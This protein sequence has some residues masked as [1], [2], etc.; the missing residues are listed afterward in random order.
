MPTCNHKKSDGLRQLAV[1]GR[2]EQTQKYNT[3]VFLAEL[4]IIFSSF[5]FHRPGRGGWGL[6]LD[7]RWAC[8][9]RCSQ[10]ETSKRP[11]HLF[12]CHL[13]PNEST[14]QNC[15]FLS[16]Y[17]VVYLVS[18]CNWTDLGNQPNDCE[19]YR[20]HSFADCRAQTIQHRQ[21]RKYTNNRNKMKNEGKIQSVHPPSN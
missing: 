16:K 21:A 2:L 8:N 1:V 9:V 14:F 12:L 3:M 4:I 20:L 15:S 10:P 18:W 7:R 6:R 11:Y 17:L 5:I 19:S 13:N